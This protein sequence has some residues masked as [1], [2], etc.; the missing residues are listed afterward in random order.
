MREEYL[1]NA[2]QLLD[3]LITELKKSKQQQSS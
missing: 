3:D 1:L 2:E